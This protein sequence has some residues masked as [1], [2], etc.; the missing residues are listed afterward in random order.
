[1]P[2]NKRPTYIGP[3]H[4]FKKFF[5]TCMVQS[6]EREH[7]V[8]LC[9]ICMKP[10]PPPPLLGC[11]PTP[12]TLKVVREWERVGVWP[13]ATPPPPPVISPQQQRARWQQQP[14]AAPSHRRMGWRGVLCSHNNAQMAAVRP[15]AGKQGVQDGSRH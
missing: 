2:L 1:M 8:I 3:P 15:P 14:P 5:A 12:Q 4:C 13:D 7:A 6:D 11:P 9:R 10:P